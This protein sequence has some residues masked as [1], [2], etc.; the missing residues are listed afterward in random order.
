MILRLA[1]VA[2]LT[3]L[4]APEIPRYRAERRIG[5]ATAA[6]RSLVERLN[7]PDAATELMRVGRVALAS[8]PDLPGDPRPY[9]IS[10]SAFLV[11]GQP[12][13]ALDSYREAFATGERAEIDLNL[14]RA[15]A[16]ARRTESADAALLRAGW[17]SPE[18]LASL[19]PEVRDPLVARLRRL[20]QDLVAGRL[21]APP[22]LPPEERR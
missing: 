18:I 15:Y 20:S 11:T 12:E 6:F 17:V 14:G 9:M 7:Q 5:L 22:P 3:W 13:P 10:G 21:S 4:V 8:T 1:A 16:L 2:A 19:S